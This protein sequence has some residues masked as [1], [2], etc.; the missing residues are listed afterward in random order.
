[1]RQLSQTEIRR[2]AVSISVGFDGSRPAPSIGT[3]LQALGEW[4][5]SKWRAYRQA[6]DDRRAEA[7]L[8]ALSDRHLKDIG[9]NRSE[10][11]SIV[12]VSEH[13]S[14]RRRRIVRR[15]PAMF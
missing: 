12:H 10:I 8:R 9:L 14:S 3:T 6:H 5:G 15:R 1:M 2:A 4:F 7:S 11:G 13:D